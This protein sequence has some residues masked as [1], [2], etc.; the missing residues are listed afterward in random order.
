MRFRF[1]H[2][3]RACYPLWLL[4]RVL[5]VSR[6]G[7]YSWRARGEKSNP[8]QSELDEAI[9]EVHKTNRRRYGTRRQVK[10]LA[11]KGR[12]VSRKT[13]RK[14]MA[15]L[16]LK[17]RYP[18]A[19]RTTTKADPSATVAPNLLDRDFHQSKPNRA[20][21]GDISYVKTASSFL[22]LAVVIDVHSRM[23]IGWSIQ[24][25]MRAE[26][27]DD[28]L[29]MALGRRAVAPGLLFHSDRGSQ[30]TSA[31][32]RKTC[33]KANIVQSMSRKGDCWDNAVSESFFATIDRELL[34]DGRSWS[35]ERSRLEIFTYIETYYNRTRLH[36]TLGY[37]SPSEFELEALQHLELG[38]M[39]A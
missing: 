32:F 25:H 17:V 13:V 1:I 15:A 19:F 4:C 38:A 10:A 28:A 14:R 9:K 26:L 5:Q 31:A 18:K 16:G 12:L 35:P 24:P 11:N 39:A 21:V 36:S 20:W 33:D 22:Y 2:A 29:R 8:D 7:Y 3:E 37:L 30:Y 34:S 27:V 23:V 6:Q